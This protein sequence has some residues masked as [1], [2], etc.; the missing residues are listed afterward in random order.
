MNDTG[1]EEP[2]EAI[3]VIGLSGRFPGAKN[4]DQF[5]Q[6]L[7]DGIESI[8]LFQDHE[9]E[10]SGIHPAALSDP[11]YVKA[12]AILEDI[13]LFDAPF[14]GISRRE[15]EIMDPQH[16]LFLECAWEALEDA[17]YDSEKYQG[18]IGV[19][20]GVGMN[21]YLLHNL[22]PNQ[23]LVQSVGAFRIMLGND[24]DFLPTQTSYKLNLK[25]PSVSIQS[26]CST[27]LVAV[28]LACQNLLNYHCDIALAGGAAILVPI[29]GGYYYQEGGVL[30]P[31]GRCRAFDAN[32][33]GT[34]PGSGVGI[35][36]LKRLTDAIADGDC[37]HA[38][39]KGS[40]VNNDG[41]L[42]VGY[43]APSV[44]GQAEVIAEALAVAGFKPEDISYIEA[45]GTGTVLGDP[46]EIA[47]LKKV[48]GASAKKKASCAIGSV[49]TNIGHLD[50]AAGVTGLIKTVLALKHRQIPP[51][52]HFETPNPA[53]D[54]EN[55]PFFVNTRLAD[56][57][58]N[59]TPR[60]AGVSSFGIGG[61][62]AHVIVEE[63]PL[64]ASPE[65]AKPAQ[66]LVLSARSDAALEAATENLLAYLKQRRDLKLA[67]VVYTLQ[68][69]RKP[70][71]RRRALVC[72]DLNDAVARLEARKSFMTGAA[73]SAKP[74]VVFMFPG[75]G[76][77]YV[78]MGGGLYRSER[79]FRE[80]VDR[81]SALLVSHLGFDL[82]EALY[83]DLQKVDEAA[84]RLM[85][86][87]LAQPALFVI[88]YALSKLW[89][90]WGIRPEAMIGHSIGEYVAACLAGVFSLED[91]LALV[92][93]RG[94]LMQQLPPGAMLSVSLTEQELRP[95]LT[96]AKLSLAAVNST[97]LCTVS[98]PS[99]AV[100]EFG[101]QL[102][103]Q[104]VTCRSLHTSHAF[105]STM[106]D[107]ILAPFVE[108]VKKIELKP[109]ALPYISN[110]TGN[111]ISEREATDVNYWAL[112]LKQTVRFAD[113]V[114]ELLKD[115]GRLLLEVGPGQTLSAFVRQRDDA[116][117]SQVFSLLRH[118]LDQRP[119][120]LFALETL[121]RLW[122]AGAEVAWDGLHDNERRSRVT[123]P[124]YPFERQR[125]WIESPNAA[126]VAAARRAPLGGKS[127]PADW[128]YRP[129]WRISS[130]P[131]PTAHPVEAPR[132]SCWLV[133]LDTC[134]VG[135]GLSRRLREK[136]F[137]VVT[138]SNGEKFSKLSEE[139]YVIDPSRRE[140]Y[141]ALIKGLSDSGKTPREIAH[142]WSVSPD[143][144][145]EVNIE[146][147]DANQML[148]FYSL[149]FLTQAIEEQNLT[150]AIQITVVSTNLQRVTGQEQLC[151]EKAT[152]L[153]PSKIIPQEYSNINCRNIDIGIPDAET[154]QDESLLDQLMME[155]SSESSDVVLAYR[156]GKR[157]AQRMESIAVDGLPETTDRLREGGVYLIT[158]GLGTIGLALAEYLAQTA[159]AKLTLIGRSVFPEE[160]KWNEW[161]AIHG[162]D[163]EVSAKIRKLKALE[164]LGAEVM[165][166]S[167]DAANELQMRDVIRRISARFGDINGVI[168]AAGITS[169]DSLVGIH[170]IS[171]NDCERHFHPKVR[172][173][174]VIEKLMRG[175]RLDF[176]LSLSSLSSFLGGLGFAAYAAANNFLDNFA[177]RQTLAGDTPWISLDLDSWRDAKKEE[178]PRGLGSSLTAFEM[179]PAEGMEV[180]RR[181]FTFDL[182]PQVAVSIGD[183]QARIDQWFRPEY[184][185]TTGKAEKAPPSLRRSGARSRNGYVAVG[186]EI[187]R[188]IAGILEE[189]LGTEE[190]GIDDNFFDLGVNSLIGI[191]II[192]D[193]KKEFDLQ[194]P[195]V[196]LFEAP[197]VRD[198][199][200][201]IGDKVGI[202][203]P[204]PSQ[205]LVKQRVYDVDR[206]EVAI[207]GMAGRF[208]GAS[209]IDQFWQ[210]L[211]DGVES[212]SY[213]SDE[214]LITAGEDPRLLSHPNYVKARP[215]LDGCDLFDAQFFGYSPREAEVTD[216]QHRLFLECS[217]EAM[218]NGGYVAENYRG[219][220][221]VFAGTNIS[222]YGMSIQS[223]P[224]ITR[225]V[226]MF[227]LAIA[228]DKD[229]LTTNVSY[230]LNLKGP[231]IAVQTHCSTS[232][233]AVHVACQNILAGEC[234]MALAGGSAIRVPQKIGYLYTGEG[235]VS[236]DGRTR[237]FDALGR[238][239]VF[240]DGV[241]VV[242]LKRLSDALADGDF[243]YAVIKGSAI[244]NDGSLKVGF[245]APSVEGQ[246][247]VVATAL[248]RAKV[249]ASTID[250]IEAHGAATRLGD[251]IEV[252]ALTKAFR[253]STEAKGFCA[254]GSVKS[255]IGHLDKA[256]GVTGLIKTTLALKHGL[257]PPSL[258]FEEANPEI[259]FENSP[260]YVNT[261]LSKW[262]R[263]GKPRRAGINSLGLGGTN[264]HVVLEEAPEKEPSGESRSWQAL[265]L[266][267]KTGSA[268]ERMTENLA[269][270]LRRNPEVNLADVAYTLQLGRR[271]FNHRRAVVCQNHDQA[272]KA[273]ES[274]NHE[275]VW[276]RIENGRHRPVAMMFPGLGEHYVNMTEGLYRAEKVFRDEVDHCCALLNPLLGVD[277]RELLF[278]AP[279]KASETANLDSPRLDLRKMLRRGSQS[280][281]IAE[282][283]LNRTFLAQPA[284]FVVEYALARLL[285]SWGLRPQAMIGHSLGEYV[286]ACLAGVFSLEA[287]LRL[288]AERARLI[289]GL[290]G[291]RM[292]A[293]ALSEEEL[294]P[295]LG[296]G[297][298]LAAVNGPRLCVLAGSE[299]GIQEV[300]WRLDA[301]EAVMR[302][303]P[304]RHAFHSEMMK[305]IEAPFR[306]LLGEV[307]LH[308]PQIPF[309][310]NV[311]GKWIREEE[312]TSV[313]YWVK[314]LCQ[315]VRFGEGVE[316]LLSG[317][318]RVV[319]EVGPGQSLSS[320]VKLHPSCSAEQ[321]PLVFSSG[322]S[323]SER[324]SDE[325][326]LMR[327]LG[328][329]WLAGVELDWE[330]FYQ[331]ERRRRAPLP[332]YPFE[333]QRYWIEARG[334]VEALPASATEPKAAVADAFYLPA[335]KAVATSPESAEEVLFGLQTSWLVFLD[336]RG[337]GERLV[338]KLRQA[339]QM[340]ATVS[341]GPAF[342]QDGS[343]HYTIN[344][345]LS[346]DYRKLI[347]ALPTPPD[348]VVQLWN[349]SE[350][351]AEW[352]T[353]E[354]LEASQEQGFYSLL[355][356]AQALGDRYMN[357]AIEL[358]V[359]SSG[360]HVV[361]GEESACPAKATLLGTC[362]VIPFEYP[363]LTCRNVDLWPITSFSAGDEPLVEQL[364][365]ELGKR[366][367][368]PVVAYRGAQR[369]VE[370]FESV[371]L[372]MPTADQAKWRE[373][374]VYLITGGLGGIGLALAEYL[375][376]KWRAKLILVGRSSLPARAEWPAL[377][378]SK[379]EA[380][381]LARKLRKLQELEAAG[382]E[383]LAL[384]ADVA[385]LGQME[386][387][388]RQAKERFGAI[389]GVIHA[390][391]VPGIGLMQLK[392]A[393]QAAH[394]MS[395]KVRGTLV[396]ERVLSGEALEL[397]VLCSSVSALI[398]GG[399]GQADYCGA[400]AFLDAY[401]E[402][403][404][405]RGRVTFSIN[406]GEWQW[407]AWQEGLAGFNQ[408]IQEHF[409]AIRR[410]YG[411]SFEE[412]C[413]A[414]E[415]IVASGRQ[416][417]IVSMREFTRTVVES[418][419][420]TAARMLGKLQ[421]RRQWQTS[422]PRPVLGTS[423]VGPRNEIE[424]GVVEIWQ[425]VLGIEKVG[426]E[427]D[428]FE[429]GGHSILATQLFSRLR[430]EFQVEIPLRE[431]F[432]L[433][434]VARQAGL[435]ATIRWA[436]QDV[437]PT[438]STSGAET[439]F[440]EG[441]L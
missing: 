80:E 169:F 285:G 237:T 427:D 164:D 373:G 412:G 345:A 364:L 202:Y 214:D 225:L 72:R 436:A 424:S 151:P 301:T 376:T 425:E 173:L 29:K 201:Y 211:V 144:D 355:W 19:Y 440:I 76:A 235:M 253:A 372:A 351:P 327:L 432:E 213:F 385:N 128:F 329:L 63:A 180:F 255:N 155:F 370:S 75:Q 250:Y 119:D 303:L 78:D 178:R 307:R 103:D 254:I 352:Q 394:V 64:S 431:L 359:V 60:R 395:P 347:N 92:A 46:I 195:V 95:R 121:G 224:E 32:A 258:N 321:A 283:E 403:E 309:V 441:E 212:L 116:E 156:D 366:S 413:E 242:L 416:R 360:L 381:G 387:V 259:D 135:A 71:N 141:S 382:T 7:R 339:N 421:E 23:E 153:G 140:H 56:W 34:V 292:L 305:E 293:V 114:K 328:K 69:G 342:L 30:S 315:T 286:A 5:W 290:P 217:W 6:N 20:A 58:A 439:N 428:F 265:V 361:T 398:G 67:D 43:T 160:E 215:I 401:A 97:S 422:H 82:R 150:D 296:S 248:S 130:W 35:V 369:W 375:A 187:E 400:N 111:W 392:T 241:A 367:V 268:L 384:S 199:A 409:K 262:E 297:V 181:I 25:G 184:P 308:S 358:V 437:V 163:D 216:P 100:N 335:W 320:F 363:Q 357:R 353:L 148:G 331:G 417:V 230:K 284:V 16:R 85:Q 350:D 142:L 185:R 434:T 105:H 343:N 218:E 408:E 260:F 50:T 275:Q 326:C 316:E 419:E 122:L 132:G 278:R 252:A 127:D 134:G 120:E 87:A 287:G 334:P 161:L 295:Y 57:Q 243:I 229:S 302:R 228:N 325:R 338:A 261:E 176:C 115:A 146:L 322:R 179:T 44:E 418:R 27:S 264:A 219:Q 380:S 267:A 17:G 222:T 167:A 40:A 340:V 47:A 410:C 172:G 239:T 269:D 221:G 104:G 126:A 368:E 124:T 279:E 233:V 223:R 306:A 183:L 227:Q 280:S 263:N 203:K 145:G 294:K 236:P 270:Y 157:W 246:A 18:L 158:G 435:I 170:K 390:A 266:S 354:G 313:E 68:V 4:V 165:I 349:V 54:L 406:W 70:F 374:G 81:C 346:E 383:V 411:I 21:I 377:L 38:V 310:S 231:S 22:Y 101:E 344:P 102:A 288:V 304:T 311:T 378:R 186:N 65:S 379:D 188:K 137:D 191:Q 319:V 138:V 129:T 108:V 33:Q 125:Y 244:N 397:L 88:E 79:V 113:G 289:E 271:V 74:S 133:F 330:A 257:L 333:R 365:A 139:E 386:A 174:L 8:S 83:L 206:R 281:E 123:L 318:E 210:N 182:G 277:L 407:D 299:E 13:D 391:G 200:K 91:A 337:F 399:P 273:L 300:E 238:G 371:K 106:M 209:S 240:G 41:S 274:L 112:H 298:S 96:D 341:R 198:L 414:L 99:E 62:N 26:A 52:L 402:R 42:K 9:L 404:R 220:I 314:H 154:L 14:F 118:P 109:P 312:A 193:L 66:L 388:V 208:P 49:K 162:D 89:M 192:A 166:I 336:E 90:S 405:A 15:A 77:Q 348:K 245:T 171:A 276:T 249:D 207:I 84:E 24:K 1:M 98:G 433:T 438:A 94:R 423:Y 117:G 36:V 256:A 190:V 152:L 53:A 430:Q 61:T 197:T 282:N 11:H 389:H 107:P 136:H 10:A 12:R 247:G 39:I 226:D 194:I 93:A 356:L 147:F 196:A 48:F 143:R 37:I 86:T 291:G 420:Y 149:I 31:D 204:T 110:V 131:K 393:D 205:T 426:V 28:C 396:L 73:E 332:T 234:D 272:A 159:R 189:K 317:T 362:R 2:I 177:Q 59:G 415:R 251:P 3:A 324:E 429:L 55:S 323:E 175:K 45:H 51:S 232:L 168:H